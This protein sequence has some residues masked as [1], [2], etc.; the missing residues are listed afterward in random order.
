M[1]AFLRRAFTRRVIE[2]PFHPT[3]AILAALTE[4]AAIE[5]L[6]HPAR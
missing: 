6:G 4:H 2:Y 3:A 5:R 1:L